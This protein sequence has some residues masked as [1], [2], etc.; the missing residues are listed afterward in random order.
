ARKL[1][2]FGREPNLGSALVSGDRLNRQAQHLFE[3]PRHTIGRIS[4]PY[5]AELDRLFRR[6]PLVEIGNAACFG[7]GTGTGVL[8]GHPE[9]LELARVEFNSW[10]SQDLVQNL[11]A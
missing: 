3:H 11:K 7:Q 2:A 5:A 4:R 9:P 8:H 1:A 10:S 6:L